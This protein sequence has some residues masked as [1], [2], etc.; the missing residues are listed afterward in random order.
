[1]G[2]T[3]KGALRLNSDHKLKVEFHGTKVASDVVLPAYRELDEAFGPT[4]AI[5]SELRD[6]RTGKNAWH[7]ITAF[8][9]QSIYGRLADYDDANDAERLCV[10]PAARNEIGCPFKT[11]TVLSY[12]QAKL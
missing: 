2:E 3:R 12:R 7:S 6:S 11:T 9:R 1:M 8:L 10:D 4:S 5:N